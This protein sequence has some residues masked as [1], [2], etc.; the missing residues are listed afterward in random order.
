[1]LAFDIAAMLA[2]NNQQL[3]VV[4][5]QQAQHHEAVMQR[6]EALEASHAPTITAPKRRSFSGGSSA[7][8]AWNAL[9]F[10]ALP[11]QPPPTV[12]MRRQQII[13]FLGCALTA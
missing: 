7:V 12:A 4:V 6:F 11:A 3:A 1:M 10:P 9:V 13:D 5:A 8:P 2:H